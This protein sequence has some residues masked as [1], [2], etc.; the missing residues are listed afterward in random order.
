MPPS[1]LD[2]KAKDGAAQEPQAQPQADGDSRAPDDAAG[3]RGREETGTTVGDRG[4]VS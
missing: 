4:G 3:G 1:A 2:P